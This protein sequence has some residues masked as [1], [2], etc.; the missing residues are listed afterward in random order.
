MKE[1]KAIKDEFN[2]SYDINKNLD[3]CHSI[4]KERYKIQCRDFFFQTSNVDFFLNVCNEA[5]YANFESE[6]AYVEWL[7][8]E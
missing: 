4:D 6:N 2:K 1:L 3:F 7:N 5:N 8:M